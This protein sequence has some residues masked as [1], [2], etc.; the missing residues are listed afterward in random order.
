MNKEY[1]YNV[2][3]NLF[4]YLSY[5]NKNIPVILDRKDFFEEFDTT[6]IVLIKSDDII[7]ILTKPN[8]KY[9]T[10]LSESKKKIKDICNA[11][12][13]IKELLYICDINYIA[14]KTNTSLNL[15]K[16]SIIEFKELY[17][18]IWF[19]IRPYKIFILDIPNCTIIPKHRIIS[20]TE[21]K[22]MLDIEHNRKNEIPQIYEWDTPVTWL[23]ARAGEFI[24][25]DRL[26]PV[27]GIQKI[28]R[29]VIL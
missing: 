17:P 14:L 26:S 19:Q 28:I 3:K 29:H 5:R 2:Y 7:I 1:I 8:T 4:K 23:G 9:S 25:I 27:V 10:F 11:N 21:A 6:N 20:N 13:N 16:K 24:E 22:K 15:V 18:H 12:E